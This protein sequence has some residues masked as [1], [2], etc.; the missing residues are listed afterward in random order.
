MDRLRRLLASRRP[1]W[2]AGIV[3]VVLV[4]AGVSAWAVR[5]DDRPTLRPTGGGFGIGTL[6]DVPFA[7]FDLGDLCSRAAHPVELVQVEALGATGGATV[8]D[9]SVDPWDASTAM[10]ART[11]LREV[12][13][14][15]GSRTVETLCRD[16]QLGQS[17]LSVEVHRPGRADA[18]VEG[19]RIWYRDGDRVRSV[20]DLQLEL[21][22]C[23]GP[24]PSDT[25]TSCLR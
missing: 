22:I 15:S 8:T 16:E 4:T 14:L 11:R 6:A 12:S 25:E 3:C 18:G 5:G 7:T 1:W 13:G 20:D 2:T 17:T 9:F 24:R 10:V 19:L 21:R 23:G